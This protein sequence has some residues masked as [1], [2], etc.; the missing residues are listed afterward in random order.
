MKLQI[1]IFTG[2]I[3][4][5]HNALNQTENGFLYKKHELSELALYFIT[6][7]RKFGHHTENQI[8]NWT[9]NWT[10]FHLIFPEEKLFLRYLKMWQYPKYD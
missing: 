5:V 4:A 1:Q 2:N 6:V 9:K 10:K 7:L 8:W 3:K